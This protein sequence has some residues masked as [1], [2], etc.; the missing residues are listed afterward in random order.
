M[1]G[2]FS[3][4]SGCD[5]CKNHGHPCN[6]RVELVIKDIPLINMVFISDQHY[7][8]CDYQEY[9]CDNHGHPCDHRVVFVISSVTPVIMKYITVIDMDI[10][11]E[12]RR[13]V[14]LI[15]IVSQ[16]IIRDITY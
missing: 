7:Y 6:H 4:E 8:T 12:I 1:G 15:S 10:F 2:R 14:A 9:Y 5:I 16:M 11:M 3:G 13:V